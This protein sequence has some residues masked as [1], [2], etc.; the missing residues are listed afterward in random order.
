VVGFIPAEGF[1]DRP[2]SVGDAMGDG[3]LPIMS[4]TKHRT[5]SEGRQVGGS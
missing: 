3:G 1:A 2:T 4:D 5:L